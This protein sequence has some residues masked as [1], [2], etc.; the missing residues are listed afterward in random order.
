MFTDICG[1]T[2]LMGED[3]ERAF[4]LLRK[5]RDLQRLLIKKYK[6]EWLKKMGDGILASFTTASDAVRCAG[7]IQNAA[8]KAG[9]PLR[10]RIHEGE[11]VF[12]GADVLGD[13]VNIASRLQESAE[14]GCITISAAVYGDVKNKADITAKFIGERKLKNVEE[15]V[16]VYHVICEKIVSDTIIREQTDRTSPEKKSIIVLPFV[17]ISPDPMQE[18]LSDGLTEEIITNLSHVHDLLVISRS[19]AMT[20]KNSNMT[21]KEIA[22]KINVQYVLE[23]SVRKADNDLRITAQLIDAF[24]DTHLW[25]EKY[26]GTLDDIFDIQEKV[27]QSIV[28]ELKLKFTYNEDEKIASNPITNI[29]AHE[30]YFKARYEL[31]K[32]TKESYDLS[33]KYLNNGLDIVGEN[34]LIYAGLGYVYWFY[35][36]GGYSDD[37]YLEKAE[38]YVIKAFELEPGIP[39]GHMVLGMIYNLRGDQI[40]FLE[41][42]IISLEH[43]PNNPDTLL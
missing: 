10:I 3:E 11:V 7:E 6:G 15:L 8:K 36:N 1:Y 13:G 19:S 12:E 30:C 35:V 28:D 27:S 40:Q 31:W 17:N 9:I 39:I 33:L 2:A 25:A 34:A 41:Q 29:H 4:Q 20:L 38:E 21:I 24:N 32:G 5:N 37:T 26:R 23:G 22:N 42:L 43:D 16:K 14:E 18:Y